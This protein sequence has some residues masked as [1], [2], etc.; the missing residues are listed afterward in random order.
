MPKI[1][2]APIPFSKEFL[3]HPKRSATMRQF[4]WQWEKAHKLLPQICYRIGNVDP[5]DVL[6]AYDGIAEFIE[7]MT[8]W[9]MR[10]SPRSFL[11]PLA[12]SHF[13]AGMLAMS[14]IEASDANSRG[15][16]QIDMRD[17]LALMVQRALDHFAMAND[18]E[19]QFESW[20]DKPR[21]KYGRTVTTC[22]MAE[23]T[24]LALRMKAYLPLGSAP[25]MHEDIV[26]RH[27]M[28]RTQA[29]NRTADIKLDGMDWL[30][31]CALGLEQNTI[32]V[33]RQKTP[34]PKEADDLDILGRDI[35]FHM[36]G[37]SHLRLF[38]LW[39]RMHE[40]YREVEEYEYGK[41][42]MDQPNGHLS[43]IHI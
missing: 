16:F 17:R 43:L 31:L 30:R 34:F 15:W 7:A 12:Y 22:A 14:W 39:K 28:Y 10:H 27:E 33:T 11:N 41:A 36:L 29:L 38:Y 24:A 2:T 6:E 20:K 23:V 32:P 19:A 18:L 21:S 1:K 5:V 37:S 35:R 13:L 42:A 3:K 26:S 9:R 4:D 8:N 25:F 40:A